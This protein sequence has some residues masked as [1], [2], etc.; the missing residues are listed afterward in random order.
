[1]TPPSTL[2]PD[3]LRSRSQAQASARAFVFLDEHGEESGELTYAQLDARAADVAVELG[4]VCAPG[5]RVLLLFLPGLDFLIAYFGCLYAGMIAV[6]VKPPRPNRLQPVTR[7]I[8]DDCAPAAVLSVSMVA[9][10]LRDTIDPVRAGLTWIAVDETPEGAG[11]GAALGPWSPDAPAFLQYTSG[12][13]SD[14]K[15]VIVSHGNLAANQVM[16]ER[17]FG[18]D[19]SSTFVGWTPLF[20]DQGLIGNVLQPLHLGVTSILMSPITFIRRPMLWLSTISR[21]R[22]HTSGGPNFAFDAC[23][24]QAAKGPLPDLDLSCWKV[25]FNGAEPIRRD[26]LDRFATTFAPIGFA[27]EA[28]YPCYGLAE[29]TLLVSGSVK[30]RGPRTF[31]ADV[32]ELE[33]GRCVAAPDGEGRTLVS[34]GRV[35]PEETVRIVEPGTGRPLMGGDIGEILIAGDHVALGYWQRPAATEATFGARCDDDDRSYLRTGDLG[36]LRD[37]ELYVVGRH[38][39]LI[40]IRGRNLYPQDIERS[41]ESSHPALRPGSCAA[42]SVT[43]TDGEALVVVAEVRRD[44]SAECG[45][46]ELTE[47]IRAAIMRDHDTA[48]ADI[49]LVD[50]AGVPKTSSGKVMRSQTRERYGDGQLDVW[51]PRKNVVAGHR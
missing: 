18:H 34:S 27:P 4:R 42:F 48:P 16:I 19:E 7:S 39:D 14:P 6:P 47:S 35:L 21:Y 51:D 3:L 24:A 17:A 50:A 13:T 10:A 43:G 30:G 20:H 8:I 49:V 46:D 15:G 36:V 25:A 44:A 29:A 45:A 1:M 28:L 37:D 9:A 40:I 41:A 12:S 2:I 38:K 11:Q 26:T 5:D 32:D 22:A 33:R 31:I 23:V